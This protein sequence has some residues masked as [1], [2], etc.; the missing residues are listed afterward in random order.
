MS[1]PPNSEWKEKENQA[2]HEII[3]KAGDSDEANRTHGRA[4]SQAS[5]RLEHE[6][7]ACGCGRGRWCCAALR[8]Q[9]VPA[10]LSGSRL[11]ASTWRVRVR[12]HMPARAHTRT[13]TRTHTS[14]RLA[15]ATHLW[16]ESRWDESLNK[17]LMIL[18]FAG[19]FVSKESHLEKS[20][21]TKT[22]TSFSSK[23]AL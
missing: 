19:T 18:G 15:Q 4:G 9:K 20:G 1:A 23:K 14:G 16:A 6:A 5:H 21:S 13:H 17:V 3:Q 10:V 11:L 12:T 7:G 2:S 22:L 8:G